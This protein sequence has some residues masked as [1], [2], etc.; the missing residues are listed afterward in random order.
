MKPLII[1][2]LMLLASCSKSGP[3]DLQISDAWARETVAGQSGT[4][5]YLTLRNVGRGDDRLIDVAA[6][7]PLTASIHSTTTSNGV[8]SMRPLPS[9]LAI[10]AGSTVELKPGGTHVMLMGLQ[11]PL[12][13]GET[14]KLTLR[15]EESGER[16]VE[17]RVASAAG[18][19]H[20]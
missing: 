1:A 7:P 18:G 5:A 13:S 20:H 4:A 9:G 17:V 6:S 3:P 16:P 8:S 10:P 11:A 19:G 14:L 15:F 2:G 12:R